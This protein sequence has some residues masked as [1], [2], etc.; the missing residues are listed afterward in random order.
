MAMTGVVSLPVI[1][2]KLYGLKIWSN[3]VN[4]EHVIGVLDRPEKWL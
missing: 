2:R 4:I 3:K 1:T